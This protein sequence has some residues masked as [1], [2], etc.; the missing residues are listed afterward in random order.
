[1]QEFFID[2]EYLTDMHVTSYYKKYQD[3]DHLTHD[4]LI[5]ALKNSSE[6]MIFSTKDPPEFTH[7][8]EQLEREGFIRVEHCWSNGDRVLKPFRLNGVKFKRHEQFGCAAAMKH[9]LEFEQQRQQKKGGEY[10]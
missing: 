2:P 7:L 4:E 3:R 5:D 9:H 10:A 8:R 6:S 1:M